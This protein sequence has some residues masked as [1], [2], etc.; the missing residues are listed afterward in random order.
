MA[1]VD[2]H[3]ILLATTPGECK[4]QSMA[5]YTLRFTNGAFVNQTTYGTYTFNISSDQIRT[6][7]NFDNR[8]K[9]MIIDYDCAAVASNKTESNS[10]KVSVD[11]TGEEFI[12]GGFVGEGPYTNSKL[13]I[14]L[15]VP[16]NFNLTVTDF[17][18]PI[19]SDFTTTDIARIFLST[20][21]SH[22]F[23]LQTSTFGIF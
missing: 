18:F 15:N 23:F 10:L 4:P 11:E 16:S 3:M 21:E 19:A 13:I 14:P 22:P 6:P 1:T 8:F 12:L 5:K 20:K 7:Q 17:V 2:P 9:T